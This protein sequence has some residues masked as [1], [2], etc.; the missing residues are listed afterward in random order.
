MALKENIKSIQQE[1]STEE[2]FLEGIIK[3]ERFIKKYKNLLI[4]FAILLL[5]GLSG[6]AIFDFMNERNLKISNE[7]Y[8]NLLKNPDDKKSL[9]ILESK[10]KA[11][12]DSY[13]FQRA[14]L[15]KDKKALEV[16]LNKTDIDPMLR[17]LAIYE[18]GK[19]GG[20]LLGHLKFALDGYELLKQN[21]INEAKVEFAKIPLS[22]PLTNVVKN[23]EHYG[24]SNE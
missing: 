7:A 22:S 3:S 21:K 15:Q 16:F 10:N 4:A 8:T 13:T 19:S 14:I 24:Q 11:L 2:Q 20:I 5:L 1:L 12:F 18:N 9:E 23:L 17:Q 6:Y